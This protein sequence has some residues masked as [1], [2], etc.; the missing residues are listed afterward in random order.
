[1]ISHAA[2]STHI[3]YFAGEPLVC[4]GSPEAACLVLVISR[5]NQEK[6]A[7]SIDRLLAAL[8]RQGCTV[9][10]FETRETQI[11][12]WLS[13][14]FD[15]F[16]A[17]FLPAGAWRRGV[18]FR[19]LAIA[20]KFG[21]LLCHP[22]KWDYFWR[23]KR[24]VSNAM[25]AASLR[26]LLAA[27]PANR[28]LLLGHSAGGIVSSMAASAASVGAVVC[29]G[30][31]FRHPQKPDEPERTAHLA[32][33]DKPCLI[34]QGSHDAYGSPD[35]ARRY[36]LS[37]SIRIHALSAGHDCDPLPESEFH[38]CLRL[39]S[40]LLRVL[41]PGTR[42]RMACQGWAGDDVFLQ[43]V[44][45][46]DLLVLSALDQLFQATLE[47]LLPVLLHRPLIKPHR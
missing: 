21:L 31:P 44:T 46:H 38:D 26:R 36:A 5:N 22:Q 19:L 9:C 12:R 20:V 29:F 32:T 30:Y 43:A 33:V 35:D 11:S 47:Y 6:P 37:A 1:M 17:R 42:W 13:L 39:I 16:A 25:R 45:R 27:M 41:L 40:R 24:S 3:H 4:L 8:H 14:A 34:F 10:W 15:A 23:R 7:H 28:V 2:M 18:A